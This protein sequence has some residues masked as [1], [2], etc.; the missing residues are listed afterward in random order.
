M[1]NYD[2]DA[3]KAAEKLNEYDLSDVLNFCAESGEKTEIFD[4]I[5]RIELI[6]PNLWRELHTLSSYEF[7]EYLH[8]MYDA[9]FIE[10][11]HYHLRPKSFKKNADI[12]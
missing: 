4:V 5:D 2:Q 10:E 8:I 12:V 11:T 1:F 9:S 7:M 6:Y 3:Y